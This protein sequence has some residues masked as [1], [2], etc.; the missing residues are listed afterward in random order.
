MADEYDMDLTGESPS[1]ATPSRTSSV[2]PSDITPKIETQVDEF[3]HGSAL[4]RKEH[5]D[6]KN[7]EEEARLKKLGLL[8]KKPRKKRAK[9]TKP[10]GPRK[11]RRKIVRDVYTVSHNEKII[12]TPL[13]NI[14]VDGMGEDQFIKQA[15]SRWGKKKQWRVWMPKLVNPK[16][17]E[18]LKVGKH[19]GSKWFD[20]KEAAR[21][22]RD[23]LWDQ[24]K[25]YFMD[26][27]RSLKPDAYTGAMPEK[28][29]KQKEGF[30]GGAISYQ[31]RRAERMAKAAL[32]PPRVY[33]RKKDVK[34]LEGVPV[35]K[36]NK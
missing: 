33:H 14:M 24:S 8:P 15:T 4:T 26:K 5:V 12:A 29:L 28:Q 7:L 32:N 6:I 25:N 31:E 27:Y 2:V 23:R 19:I 16:L 20:S 21:A 1:T 17:Y 35:L 36:Y 18:T 34:G 30:G 22:E 9:E 13:W 10:R 11:A 3:G